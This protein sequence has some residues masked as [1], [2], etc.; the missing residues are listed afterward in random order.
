MGSKMQCALDHWKMF[1]VD[2]MWSPFFLTLFVSKINETNTCM[3][4][5]QMPK[6][7][8]QSYLL[9]TTCL[10]LGMQPFRINPMRFL[11]SNF[12][13]KSNPIHN[14]HPSSLVAFG[15]S[16][17]TSLELL[18]SRCFARLLATYQRWEFIVMCC[19]GSACSVQLAV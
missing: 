10:S 9:A 12:L 17:L 7:L 6:N 18:L 14:H 11:L 1:K 15:P 5:W 2:K 8:T 4:S 16:H 13:A 19:Q 3:S